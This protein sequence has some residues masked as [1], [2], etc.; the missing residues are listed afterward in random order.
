MLKF[1]VYTTFASILV[2]AGIALEMQ[3]SPDGVQGSGL[4]P[5][6]ESSGFISG[7]RGS[8]IAH[9]PASDVTIESGTIESGT[10]ESGTIEPGAGWS[11]GSASSVSGSCPS[12]RSGM[13]PEASV[14]EGISSSGG[15]MTATSGGTAELARGL[16]T[17]GLSQAGATAEQSSTSSPAGPRA[18]A[19]L[20][21]T[22]DHPTAP[23]GVGE[24]RVT[25]PD[26]LAAAPVAAP[27][28]ASVPGLIPTPTPISSPTPT[29][30]SSPRPSSPA[31]VAPLRPGSAPG[32]LPASAT[33]GKHWVVQL[34][35]EA[36]S[37][38]F[39]AFPSASP[40]SPEQPP[41]PALW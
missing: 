9:L 39:P 3:P 34:S 25:S 27:V 17:P 37:S 41:V 18:T 5:E 21:A 31:T 33:G 40:F 13:S 6:V 1:F 12:P 30:I 38:R 35:S 2:G 11:A 4:P 24:V 19:G 23:Q 15:A 26:T 32:S 7:D 20:V 10:I 14:V 29:P 8:A 22:V 28:A 16:A 36:A